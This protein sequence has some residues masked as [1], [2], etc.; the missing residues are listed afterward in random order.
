MPIF[1]K[2][3]GVLVVRVV[4]DG[5]PMSGKTT[6]LRALANGL[7]V[8]IT[9]PEERDGRTLFF[10][11]VEYVGGIFEGR[12]IRC[13]IVSVPGQK[14]LAN[15][16]RRLLDAADAVVMVADTRSSAIDDAYVLLG[17]LLQW[18]RAQEPPVGV[19]IQ[20]N[21][22]D[23]PDSVPR[24]QIH[25]DFE[26]IAPLA[27]IDTVATT[28]EGVREAFV[29]A[30][31]LALDRVRALAA[32][33]RLGEGSPDVDGPAELMNRL[34]PLSIAPLAFANPD[35]GEAPIAGETTS[36]DVA[37]E[38]EHL[39][40]RPR[41]N[42]SLVAAEQDGAAERVFVPDPL[43]PG[44]FIWPPVD[45][46]MLLHEVAQLVRTPVLTPCGDWWAAGEGW[47]FHSSASSLFRSADSGRQ[48]LIEWARLHVANVH[49][50]SP[51]RTVILAD[52][53]GGR[54]RLWQLVRVSHA[55]RDRLV[56]SMA[57]ASAGELARELKAA[58]SHLVRARSAFTGS[59][60]CLPC[61]L[62]TVSGDLQRQPMFVGL[63]PKP[64]SDR[65]DELDESSLVEREFLPLLRSLKNERDDFQ[66]VVSALSSE[67]GSRT[68]ETIGRLAASGV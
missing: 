31:R 29:F 26:R 9:S 44:G 16:R 40:P 1:D 25:E 23:E 30:V 58:A 6:T 27:V 12:Q 39:V 3:R 65:G 37:P 52:A 34:A 47:R 13:Q 2:E 4:Y 50:L 15:R 62:W 18:T 67:N 19:V 28:G 66:T 11:W 41:A 55:L 35:A 54:F 51:G 33:R 14:E 49:R 42:G 17:D 32:A 21:K 43:M 38:Y 48:E 22:R 10:D 5:P 64:G 59:D 57:E 56:A 46:R 53:G 63:M 36:A 45:G 24:A 61:T 20:A 7:G 8:A 60:I 68:A